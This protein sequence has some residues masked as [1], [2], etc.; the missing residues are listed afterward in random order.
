[1]KQTLN[2]ASVYIGL[3]IGAGFASG[4]EIYQYFCIPSQADYTGIILAATCFGLLAYIIMSLAKSQTA[5]TFDGFI[6][7]T[8]P[9]LAPAIKAFMSAYMFCGFFVMLSASGTLFEETLSLPFGLGVFALAAVC[10]CVFSFDLKGIVA[11]N[12]IMVPVMVIGM[13]LLCVTSVL[14]GIPAFSFFDRLKSNPLAC[15]LCY[16]SYNTISAGAVLV[17]LARNAEKSSLKKAALVSSAVLW[18][19]IF[20]VWLTLNTNFDIFHSVQMPLLDLAA[21]HGKLYQT[22][23]SVVLFMALC[24]TAISHGFGIL[25][26]LSFKKSSDRILAS[27]I[28]CLCAMP[29]AKFG[30][31]TLIA[32][33]YSAFGFIGIFW[34]ALVL[35]RYFRQR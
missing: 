8:A 13:I 28:L 10:F 23:Y 22:L 25:S 34:T 18:L 19:L 6:E 33:L 16:V 32:K 15:A 7:E 5:S 20:L 35:L 1:M 26:K 14:C 21:F 29:F 9:K 31:S 17:P 11:I 24:T 27:A 12:N 4:R 3:I 30:F 2:I